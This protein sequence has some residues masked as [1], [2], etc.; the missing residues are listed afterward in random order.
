[1]IRANAMRHNHRKC[2]EK[3]EDCKTLGKNLMVLTQLS[4]KLYHYFK[5]KS[6]SCVNTYIFPYFS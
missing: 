3:F 1:M 2:R 4:G 5:W 6:P